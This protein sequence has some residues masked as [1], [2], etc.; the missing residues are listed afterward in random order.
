MKA[1]KRAIITSF[2][3]ALIVLLSAISAQATLIMFNS[4]ALFDA[5]VPGLPVETFESG[6]VSA[7]QVTACAGPLSSSAASACFLAGALLPGVIYSSTSGPMALLGAGFIPAIGNTTKVLGPNLFND[8]FDI[9]F[10]A[11]TA[12]GLDLFTGPVV[13]N[14]QVSIFGPTNQL[15]GS[16]LIAV[17]TGG[18]FVGFLSDASLI[19]H[20]TIA[21]Q[22]PASGELVDNL[23]FGVAAAAIPE[24]S[25]LLLVG[26]GLAAGAAIS[27]RRYHRSLTRGR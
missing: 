14:V 8:S 6:L 15:L 17:P 18:I 9:T 27:R 12:A 24:S 5:A 4:R 16:S 19:G 11:A 1:I 25:T 21:G 26:I 23:A 10:A 2:A 22:S 7:G 20:I 13:G 3:S